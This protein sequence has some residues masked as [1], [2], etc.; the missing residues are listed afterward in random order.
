MV[1]T[2]LMFAATVMLKAPAFFVRRKA[3]YVESKRDAPIDEQACGLEPR[4]LVRAPFCYP[5]Q[6]AAEQC[7]ENTLD[8]RQRA[9]PC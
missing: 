3:D 2:C 5:I 8:K 7:I 6:L 9:H 1:R 4:H